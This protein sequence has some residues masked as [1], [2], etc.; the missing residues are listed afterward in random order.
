MGA[1]CFVIPGIYLAI[2][3]SFVG[4]IVVFNNVDGSEA[5]KASRKVLNRNF[6]PFFGLLIIL[7]LINV[8]G[9]LCLVVGLL[10][11]VPLSKAILFLAYKDVF[12]IVEDEALSDFNE[13]G[14]VEVDS[15]FE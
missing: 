4:L 5:L 15:N 9:F 2:V 11:T 10:V 13:F 8:L 12:G 7:F 6:W 3:Y 14:T 1:L